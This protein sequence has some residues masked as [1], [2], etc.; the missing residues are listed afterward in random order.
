MLSLLWQV[1]RVHLMKST[2]HGFA[3]RARR[4]GVRK[5]GA[6]G[7]QGG[8]MGWQGGAMGWQGGPGR[9]RT[10]SVG[11]RGQGGDYASHI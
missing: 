2:S 1:L 10:G 6:M 3:G 9:G 8:A 7:W 11:R 4:G 5:G